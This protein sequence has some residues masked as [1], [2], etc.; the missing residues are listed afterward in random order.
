VVL[1]L[2]AEPGR[3]FDA[4]EGRVTIRALVEGRPARVRFR[5]ERADDARACDAHRDQ[6]PVAVTGVLQRAPQARR[7]DLREPRGFAVL[8]VAAAP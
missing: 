7:F 1:G 5:L 4:F 3:L 2:Q 8:G 6:R